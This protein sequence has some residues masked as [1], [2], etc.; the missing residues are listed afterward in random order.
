MFAAPPNNEFEFDVHGQEVQ[1]TDGAGGIVTFV[2]KPLVHVV[3]GFPGF[4]NGGNESTP[5]T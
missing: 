5:A 2:P 4:G 1:G 3:P